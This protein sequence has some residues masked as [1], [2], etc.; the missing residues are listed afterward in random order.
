MSRQNSI[1]L[2]GTD[3]TPSDSS[4]L[5]RLGEELAV[6][7]LEARGFNIVLRNFTVTLRRN[8]RNARVSGEIDV[9]AEREGLFYLVEVKTRRKEIRFSP[10]ASIDRRK[11]RQL[12]RTA[13]IYRRIFK[14]D[15][16]LTVF[17][18]V[19]ILI[20]DRTTRPVIR[21]QVFTPEQMHI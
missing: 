21:F 3:T 5:G 11:K 10:E 1:L 14:I 2:K 12:A 16:Q 9:I 18:S 13:S 6:R 7:Y 15:R 4:R 8:S 20:A 19:A 17:A